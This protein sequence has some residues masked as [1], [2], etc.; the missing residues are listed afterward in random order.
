MVYEQQYNRVD[1]V[2]VGA[3]SIMISQKKDR[4]VIYL[5]NTSAAAQVITIA[6]DNINP[7][8]AGKGIVLSPGEYV[9]DS[10]SEGYKAWNGDISAISS[11]AGGTLAVM[12][13]PEYNAY[14]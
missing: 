12:E 1:T 7:A 14:K 11:A 13:T 2:T 4:K 8:V 3:T 6:F 5:R 9:L 10:S